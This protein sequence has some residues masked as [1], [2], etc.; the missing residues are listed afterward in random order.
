MKN[1][2]LNFE[3]KLYHGEIEEYLPSFDTSK[4]LSISKFFNGIAKVK[5]AN[6][7]YTFVNKEGKVWG[8][9]YKELDLFYIPANSYNT[10]T[11]AKFLND[12]WAYLNYNGE[13]VSDFYEE[14]TDFN[15]G[16][17]RGKKE[18]LWTYLDCDFNEFG[19]VH[20]KLNNFDQ[21]G[22]A[23][24]ESTKGLY[25][26]MNK[27]GEILFHDFKKIVYF[28]HKYYF[29]DEK[30]NQIFD[31]QL[32]S[33]LNCT[34]DDVKRVSNGRMVALKKNTLYVIGKF[35]QI[36]NF[37]REVN[38]GVT[39]QYHFSIVNDSIFH[40]KAK[41]HTKRENKQFLTT[42]LS[43]NPHFVKYIDCFYFTVPEYLDCIQ[44]TV[45]QHIL[46]VKSSTERIVEHISNKKYISLIEN[47]VKD[48]V[49]QG[50]KQAKLEKMKNYYETRQQQ[51]EKKCNKINADCNKKIIELS[52]QI[53]EIK[54]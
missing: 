24:I 8:Q 2:T 40:Y 25:S 54:R 39:N 16:V 34:Y 51:A 12:K 36:E 44:T 14:L 48:A 15:L 45:S 38:S 47:T 26:F 49:I 42:I 27:K 53:E 10:V 4:F 3:Y 5:L 46:R 1:P 29:F 19:G 30:N 35:N 32:N 52:N 37:E 28:H 22:Y 21:N 13:R 6:G 17:A 50:Q 18:G 20:I 33:T 11:R 9:E 43:K 41:E 23:M 31:V 7:H